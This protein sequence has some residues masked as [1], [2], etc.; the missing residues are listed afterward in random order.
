LTV[1]RTRPG[2][3][4]ARISI[5]TTTRLLPWYITCATIYRLPGAKPTVLPV[6]RF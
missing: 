1:D 5:S 4:V 6:V 3:V 2:Q